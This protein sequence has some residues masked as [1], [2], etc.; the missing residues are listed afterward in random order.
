MTHP[1]SPALR[2]ELAP[3][4]TLRVGLNLSNFLLVNALRVD[5]EPAGI[6]PDIGR[7]IA[8]R[9]RGLAVRVR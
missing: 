1:I 4:G 9:R 5:G 3:S 7:E 2:A 6:A 8:R